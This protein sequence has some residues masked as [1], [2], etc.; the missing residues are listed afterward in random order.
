M[1][2]LK[3]KNCVAQATQFLV[4]APYEAILANLIIASA[5]PPL[6]VVELYQPAV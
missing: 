3:T 2:F 5:I 1:R 6:A 4:D